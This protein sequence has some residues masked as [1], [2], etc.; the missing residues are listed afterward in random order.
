LGSSGFRVF[1]ETLADT[2]SREVT[3]GLLRLWSWWFGVMFSSIHA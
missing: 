2:F 1:N 3:I